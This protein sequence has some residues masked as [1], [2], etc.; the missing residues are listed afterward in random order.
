M[1]DYEKAA[2]WFQKAANQNDS[3][4]QYRLGYCYYKGQ[5][6]LKNSEKAAYWYKK[7]AEQ[8]KENARKALNALLPN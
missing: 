5:G 2:Y 6:V 8:G 4:A 1:I 7:A 3:Y